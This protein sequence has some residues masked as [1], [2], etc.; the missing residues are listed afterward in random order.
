MFQNI[1]SG[2]IAVTCVVGIIVGSIYVAD[3]VKC[4]DMWPLS[5]SKVCA[6]K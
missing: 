6:V 3:H 1:L 5:P 2:L 4:F